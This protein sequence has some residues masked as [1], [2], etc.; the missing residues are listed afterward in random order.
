MN[1]VPAV[2]T[3]TADPDPEIAALALRFKRANGPVMRLVNRL[4]G[5]LEGKFGLVPAPIRAR[6]E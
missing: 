6:I 2:P 1:Q 4:G 5:Q 3:V